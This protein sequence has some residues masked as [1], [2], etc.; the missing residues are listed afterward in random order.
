MPPHLPSTNCSRPCPTR[1]SAAGADGG[2]QRRDPPA[3][4]RCGRQQGGNA[5]AVCHSSLEALALIIPETD[6]Y[7]ALGSRAP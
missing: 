6:N 5:T 4:R 7:T 1:D 3:G 2:A